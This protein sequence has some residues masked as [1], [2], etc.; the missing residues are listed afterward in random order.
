MNVKFCVKVYCFNNFIG[1]Y[2]PKGVEHERDS[3]SHATRGVFD[4]TGEL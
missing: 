3:R 4:V 2:C 1:N